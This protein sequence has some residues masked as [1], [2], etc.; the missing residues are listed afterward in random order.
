MITAWATPIT[1]VFARACRVH[2]KPSMWLR[3]AR[4]VCAPCC[5]DVAPV[6]SHRAVARRHSSPRHAGRAE[7][8]ITNGLGRDRGWVCGRKMP[9][10]DWAHPPRRCAAAP[11]RNLS[12]TICPQ[13]TSPTRL[14][15]SFARARALLK[16]SVLTRA[17]RWRLA[18]GQAVARQLSHRSPSAFWPFPCACRPA[19]R[20]RSC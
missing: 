15:G 5:A 19:A 11:A 8:A 10:S 16:P 12:M 4:G 13:Q 20:R 1:S 3:T 9:S 18:G 6:C 17:Q 2:T 14:A 7:A